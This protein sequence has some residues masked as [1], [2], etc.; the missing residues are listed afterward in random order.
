[1]ATLLRTY[2]Q[3]K[4]SPNKARGKVGG[5]S[6]HCGLPHFSTV[7]EGTFSTSSV[8]LSSMAD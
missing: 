1:M 4:K 2:R 3:K 5:P 8:A 7:M 6:P